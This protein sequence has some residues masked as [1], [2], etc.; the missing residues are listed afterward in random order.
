MTANVAHNPHGKRIRGV[1]LPQPKFELP[2]ADRDETA[3][4]GRV[5]RHDT[6]RPAFTAQDAIDVIRRMVL[7]AR[8]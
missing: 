2:A 7:E 3:P 5:I 6:P 4:T 1:N 8:A